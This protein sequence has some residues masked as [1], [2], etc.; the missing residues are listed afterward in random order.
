MTRKEAVNYLHKNMKYS[1]RM[2][3]KLVDLA[4]LSKSSRPFGVA[5]KSAVVE[6]TG[7]IEK[8]RK[9]GSKDLKKRKSK[10]KIERKPPWPGSPAR[11][12][13]R[14]KYKWTNEDVSEFKYK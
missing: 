2:S 12:K 5:I 3:A 10:G 4:I 9:P 8:A 6:A 13:N 7:I 11:M 14:D 1:R